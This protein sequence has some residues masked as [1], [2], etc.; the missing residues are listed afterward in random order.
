MVGGGG[1]E[2]EQTQTNIKKVAPKVS[3]LVV[4]SN[5]EE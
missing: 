4:I 1:G 5:D 2:G 3:G